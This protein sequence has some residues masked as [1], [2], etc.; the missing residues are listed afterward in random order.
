MTVY[1]KVCEKCV[2]YKFLIEDPDLTKT[3][4]TDSISTKPCECPESKIILGRDMEEGRRRIMSDVVCSYKDKCTSHPSR[5]DSCRNNTGKR[6]Y[7]EPEPQPYIPDYPWYPYPWWVPYEP[8]WISI[9]YSSDE[10]SSDY[11]QSR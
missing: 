3:S 10:G 2:G 5:C 6:D 7:Y 4:G 1:V 9:R 11:Y 8:Y